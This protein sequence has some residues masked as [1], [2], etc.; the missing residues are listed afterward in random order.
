MSNFINQFPYADFHE[1]N[2][3]WLLAKTKQLQADMT[4]MQEQMENL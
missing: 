1:L 2:L 3:D 4:A